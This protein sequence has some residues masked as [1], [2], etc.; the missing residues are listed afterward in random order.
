MGIAGAMNQSVFVDLWWTLWIISNLLGQFVFRYSLKSEAVDDLK[1]VT[2]AG[3]ISAAFS[4]PLALFTIKVI[5]DY[6]AVESLLPEV[7]AEQN[8]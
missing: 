7:A 2:M 3:L 6:S 4:I 5:K 1:V 8:A